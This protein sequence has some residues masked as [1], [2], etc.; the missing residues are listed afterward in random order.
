MDFSIQIN[1][2]SLGLFIIYLNGSQVE[3]FNCV[4]QSLKIFLPKKT[5]QALNVLPSMIDFSAW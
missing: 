5:V 4:L 1:T 2:M 3:I